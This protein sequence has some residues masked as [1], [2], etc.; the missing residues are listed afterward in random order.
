MKYLILL[1]LFVN[2]KAQTLTNTIPSNYYGTWTNVSNTDT[3]FIEPTKVTFTSNQGEIY[4]AIVDTAL[5]ITPTYYTYLSRP[6]ALN[7]GLTKISKNKIVFNVIDSNGLGIR[8]DTYFKSGV[9][10]AKRKK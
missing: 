3:I 2:C 10:T 9:R 8:S 4:V 7:I 6:I 5:S 1:F